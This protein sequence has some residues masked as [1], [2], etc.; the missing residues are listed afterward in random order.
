ME[1]KFDGGSYVRS[2]YGGF[3]TVSGKDE[4]LQ[5]AL[6]RLSAR[7]GSF[8]PLPDFGSELHTLFSMKKSQRAAAARRMVYEALEPEPELTAT[9]VDYRET[10]DGAA[11]VTVALELSGG[12]SGE[13]SV[14]IVG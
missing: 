11:V 3:V 10:G 8:F 4:Q 14:N 1:L 6:M 5:R 2:G 13:V 9:G 12:G 7:R